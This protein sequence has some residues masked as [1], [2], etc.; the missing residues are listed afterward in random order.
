MLH[1]ILIIIAI[2]APVC[3]SKPVHAAGKSN[4]LLQLKVR[5]STL[6]G[7]VIAGDQREFWLMSRDGRL[8]ELSFG[9]VKSFDELSSRFQG[10][11]A[12]EIRDQLK[13]EFGTEYEVAAKGHYVVCARRGNAREYAR[14]LD[15]IYNRFASY[16]RVRQLKLTK[17]EFPMVALVFPEHA[18][19]ARYAAGDGVRAVRGLLGYYHPH[20]NRVAL[21]DP[22]Q[23]AAATDA[24]SRIHNDL[25][26]LDP[27]NGNR[28]WP[29]ADIFAATGSSDSGL[30]DTM[31][32]EGT[33]QIAF[34]MGL[35]TRIG[36]NPK[37][38]VEGL[39]TVFEAPGIREGSSRAKASARINRER[40]VW[41]MNYIQKRRQ[42]NSLANFI[43][44]DKY[45]H[46]SVLDGY[47]QA[48]ALSF[49]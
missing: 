19:F 6:E 30:M 2:C 45:F 39:A 42:K 4:A 14:L 20:T 40:F 5:D 18:G 17:P 23:Q 46:A 47:S 26:I 35:H 21:F 32:H 28:D 29:T 25:A 34:N 33:H 3:I 11:S 12:V 15:A 43:S 37:W 22:G 44:D 49:T 7:K 41:F 48:W 16:F 10:Y 13:R 1:K 27:W 31:I 8:K 24:A 9:E 38:I 36:D